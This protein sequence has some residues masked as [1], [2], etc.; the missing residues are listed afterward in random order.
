MGWYTLTKPDARQG[1]VCDEVTGQT[2][3]VVYDPKNVHVLAASVDLLEALET[4][5]GLLDCEEQMSAQ[6]ER[7]IRNVI[8]KAKG[9]F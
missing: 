1:T 5:L 9:E 3:A 8:Y 7:D 2:I 6:Q 4:A